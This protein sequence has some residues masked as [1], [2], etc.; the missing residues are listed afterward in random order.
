MAA[1][2]APST[3]RFTG[4]TSSSKLRT[5]G[6]LLRLARARH[7][8]A[9]TTQDA[10]PGKA[11]PD[12]F[13]EAVVRLQSLLEGVGCAACCAQRG[14]S[15]AHA[16]QRAALRRATAPFRATRMHARALAQ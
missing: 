16:P 11:Q 4:T 7:V 2:G 6:P 5:R 1:L 14:R 13:Y 9:A 15:A 10:P 12:P 3:L 8:A